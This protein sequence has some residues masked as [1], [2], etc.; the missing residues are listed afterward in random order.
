MHLGTIARNTVVGL[1]FKV[2][3]QVLLV[4]GLLLLLAS[5]AVVSVAGSAAIT[6]A[7]ALISV[8]S[9]GRL[10]RGFNFCVGGGQ[11]PKP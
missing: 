8:T 1:G 2:F 4:L 5:A 11:V 6:A 7:T 3:L 10:C 9:A